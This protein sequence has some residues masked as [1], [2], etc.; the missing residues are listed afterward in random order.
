MEGGGNDGGGPTAG[1]ATTEASN[2]AVQPP[3]PTRACNRCRE[4]HSACDAY[5][6]PQTKKY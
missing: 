3:V 1:P 2:T 4:T 6:P 5:A